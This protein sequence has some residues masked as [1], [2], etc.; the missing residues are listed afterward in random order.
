MVGKRGARGSR[1]DSKKKD[2]RGGRIKA[3]CFA[4]EKV[5]RFCVEKVDYID[6]KD[7]RMLIA[8]HS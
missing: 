4:V 6:Y 7:A 1:R 8:V 2:D 3:V 5:C